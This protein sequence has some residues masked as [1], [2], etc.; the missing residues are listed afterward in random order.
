M[1]ETTS[2]ITEN[3]NF[4]PEPTPFNKESESANNNDVG[5]PVLNKKKRKMLPLIIL[6]L[7]LLAIAFAVYYVFFSI[8]K[9]DEEEINGGVSIEQPTPTTIE[10]PVEINRSEVAIEILNG[11][12]IPGEAKKLQEKIEP[13]GYENFDIA[14]AQSKDYETTVVTFDSSITQTVKDEIM[15]VLEDYFSSV[16]TKTDSLSTSKIVIITGFPKDYSP[17]PTAT[18]SVSTP[19]STPTESASTNTPTPTE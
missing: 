3:D 19:T 11:T 13:L 2:Q 8:P 14:N 9:V 6:I 10:T 5:F 17:E 12:S 4:S 16:E 1:E 18:K 15:A 7:I